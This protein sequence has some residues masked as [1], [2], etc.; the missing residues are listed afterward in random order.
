MLLQRD[1]FGVTTGSA[2]VTNFPDEP[3]ERLRFLADKGNGAYFLLGEAGS[4]LTYW[5]LG[6]GDAVPWTEASNLNKYCYSNV[7]G[8][9]E[10]IIWWLQK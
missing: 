5:Q 1:K 3:C 8:T 7:S 10:R 9:G 6:A 4:G 2:S